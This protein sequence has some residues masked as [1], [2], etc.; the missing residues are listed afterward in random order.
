L[1]I[2][3]L[4]RAARAAADAI[5]SRMGIKPWVSL[6]MS[7]ALRIDPGDGCERALIRYGRLDVLVCSAALDPKFEPQHQG[8]YG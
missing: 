7:P 5:C 3:N 2:L 4:E 6:W 1:Q 8:Q